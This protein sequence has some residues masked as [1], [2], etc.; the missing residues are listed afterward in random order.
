MHKN[1]S[2]FVSIAL[3]FSVITNIKAEV[4]YPD[5]ALTVAQ[6]FYYERMVQQGILV[7][8]ND[9]ELV[10]ASEGRSNELPAFYAFDVNNGGFVIVSG[11]DGYTPIIG[12]S[13]QGNFPVH[14]EGSDFGSFLY[15]Y[16]EQIDFLRENR[17]SPKADVV[18]YW[19]DLSQP[20]TVQYAPGGNR[21]IEPLILSTWNQ[22]Y[23]YNAYCPLDPAGPGG[24]VYAGCVATAM[25]MI[26]HYYRYPEHGTGSHNYY[27]DP[28]GN[29]SANFGETWYDW[30]AMTKN[31]NSNSGQAINAIAELQYQCGV[32]MNMGYSPDG[33]GA[34]SEQ[35]PDAIKT[36]FG[37]SSSAQHMYKYYYT[38]ATWENHIITSMDNLQPLYYSGRNSSGGHAFVLDG[39]QNTS[40][41]N[42]FHFNFG[43]GG[44]GNGFYTL[45]D[46]YGFSSNQAM[47]RNFFPD[48]AY[49]PYGCNNHVITSSRGSFEDNSGPLANYESN[50]HCTWLIH[51][52]DSVLDIQVTFDRFELGSGDV[53]NIYD[54]F[55]A[56]APLIASYNS[57]DNSAVV[58][59]SGS[60]LFVELITDE[61]EN[62]Q[63]FVA[64][65][66]STYPAFCTSSTTTYTDPDGH[67][68][69]GSGPKNYNNN[70]M[71]KWKIDP[72]ALA[73]E[74]TLVFTEF[75][76]EENVDFIKIFSI[77]DYQ[78]LGDFT[79]STLPPSVVSATGKMMIIF[80]SNGYNTGAGFEADYYT[81]NV[82]SQTQEFA[83]NLAIFPNPASE[84]ANLKFSLDEGAN[85]EFGIF[86]MMGQRV[87]NESAHLNAGFIDR[88]LQFGKLNPGVY[89]MRISSPKGSI[90]QRLVVN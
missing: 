80:S 18:Q 13:D 42:L 75:D 11:D 89:V 61:T 10:L 54:G 66:S 38:N 6:N 37:Y 82:S 74:L 81:L 15:E 43:W 70:T 67:I 34:Y 52:T 19:A 79:G 90:S 33:S 60:M 71:C 40:S 84:Y 45:S 41:G 68:S 3:L 23:P 21:S 30:D 12:Y 29:I 27:L 1:F 32:S 51:P 9:I 39:Y 78:V 22:D 87:Y 44:S 26:M 20:V 58:N 77:P 56:S 16:I 88:T 28:Y 48:P 46:V 65:F 73:N 4:V 69:D 86:N 85:V 24:R 64:A 8:H 62:G 7:N 5:R 83:G 59:S 36:Y 14:Y 25:A 76:L 31:I 47:V 53:V 35:V 49:Y 2:F 63:G 17:V 50:S 57:T 72:G 55:D